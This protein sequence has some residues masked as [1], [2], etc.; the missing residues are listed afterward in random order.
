MDKKSPVFGLD[1]TTIHV[2][3]NRIWITY[4]RIIGEK[5]NRIL[6]ASPKVCSN[7][8]PIYFPFFNNYWVVSIF[9][10]NS[11]QIK[12]GSMLS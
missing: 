8:F 6:R 1:W 2:S 3:I 4:I 5:R 10:S 7:S 11:P 12:G 9:H